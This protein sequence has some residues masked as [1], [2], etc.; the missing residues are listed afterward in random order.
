MRALAVL[1]STAIL[2]L[3]SRAAGIEAVDAS[4]DAASSPGLTNYNDAASD[5]VVV[6]APRPSRA[7]PPDVASSGDED[8]DDDDDDDDGDEED[9]DD[10]DDD[11]DEE[12]HQDDYDSDD[13]EGVDGEDYEIRIRQALAHYQARSHDLLHGSLPR[14]G[15]TTISGRG[16][17]Q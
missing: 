1:L 12:E 17:R 13:E 8:D 9:H 15:G 10:Y 2:L 6:G 3:S 7:L 11:D 4:A 14:E 5:S 16:G